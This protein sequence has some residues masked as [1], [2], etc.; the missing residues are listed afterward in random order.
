MN[1]FYSGK[2]EFLIQP[3]SPAIK[4]LTYSDSSNVVWEGCGEGA[5]EQGRN[6]D[7]GVV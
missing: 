1:F 3:I 4:I 2:I 6:C 5:P 7:G